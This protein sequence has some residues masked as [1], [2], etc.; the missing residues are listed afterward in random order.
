MDDSLNKG[1]WQQLMA[2]KPELLEM[3]R[4]YELDGR[5]YDMLGNLD[6]MV[7]PM[8]PVHVR[9]AWGAEDRRNYKNVCILEARQGTVLI[10][11]FISAD[12]K[13]VLRVA[14]QEKLPVAILL[15]NGIAEDYEMPAEWWDAF[16]EGNLLLLADGPYQ[17]AQTKLT[18]ERCKELNTIAEELAAEDW[19]E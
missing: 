19:F 11:P 4:G 15:T 3:V 16:A 8:K 6:L 5:T 2:E 9:L 7:R 12:E 1:S 13:Q 17:P 10:G 14:L 18:R